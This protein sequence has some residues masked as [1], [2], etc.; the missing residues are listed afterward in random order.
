MPDALPKR[1]QYARGHEEE[2]K[3]LKHDGQR[4]KVLSID[5][6]AHE[7]ADGAARADEEQPVPLPS[8]TDGTKALAVGQEEPA[9]LAQIDHRGDD[10]GGE[11]AADDD[12][13]DASR[14]QVVVGRVARRAVDHG[15]VAEHDGSEFVESE[16][17]SRLVRQRA[18]RPQRVVEE[19]QRRPVEMHAVDENI[20]RIVAC[21]KRRGLGDF[22][23]T[24]G[25]S[26]ASVSLALPLSRCALT[27]R[28]RL[29][30]AD[31][32]FC[33]LDEG[34]VREWKKTKRRVKKAPSSDGYV[35]HRR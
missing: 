12:A 14:L 33:K 31:V 23:G 30:K 3:V 19:L 13:Q 16:V 27:S 32:G 15:P 7:A 5:I 8:S 11:D 4:L 29:V 28:G 6:D 20:R 34:G 9:M 18:V 24:H 26:S 22:E 2:E 17:A 10:G 25:S 35:D 1:R 21:R